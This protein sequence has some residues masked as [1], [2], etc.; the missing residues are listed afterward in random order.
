MAPVLALSP[1]LR[2]QARTLADVRDFIDRTV[3]AEG[4]SGQASPIPVLM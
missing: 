1:L 2:F 4:T 3:D